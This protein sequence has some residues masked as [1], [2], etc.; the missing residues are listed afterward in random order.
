MSIKTYLRRG[1]SYVLH[2]QPVENHCVTAQIVHLAPNELLK[3]RTALVTGGTSGIG[4]AIATAFICSFDI[5]IL[6]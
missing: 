3:G 6:E 2:G 1:I 5:S 4:R